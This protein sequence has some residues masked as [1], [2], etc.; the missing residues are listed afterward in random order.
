MAP[1]R[2]QCARG[3]RAAPPSEPRCRARP[4]PPGSVRDEPPRAA[5]RVGARAAVRATRADRR[6]PR[7]QPARSTM[8]TQFCRKSERP[9]QTRRLRR[10]SREAPRHT[11]PERGSAAPEGRRPA[12]SAA[13][14]RAPHRRARAATGPGAAAAFGAGRPRSR[15]KPFRRLA[16]P[17]LG[18]ALQGTPR[19]GRRP[20][21]GRATA[22]HRQRARPRHRGA[23]D[24]AFGRGRDKPKRRPRLALHRVPA[25]APARA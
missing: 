24:E 2:R 6:A 12:G 13:I 18:A 17:R 22:P 16:S 9:Y 21:R 14:P 10:R 15:S 8:K 20:A 3:R 23:R 19:P 11:R 1:R 4:A 7:L 5:I 25:L